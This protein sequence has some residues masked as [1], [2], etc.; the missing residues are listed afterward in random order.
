MSRLVAE[1][2]YDGRMFD[3][4]ARA[5]MAGVEVLSQYATGVVPSRR[6]D[7]RGYHGSDKFIIAIAG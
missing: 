4:G 7:G 2:I 5:A 3:P 1:Q 6:S